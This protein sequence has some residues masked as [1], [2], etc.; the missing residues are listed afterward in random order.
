MEDLT[1]ILEGTRLP[2]LERLGLRD[3][4]RSDD[5]AEMIA[6]AAITQ[7]LRAVDL[8]LGTLGDEGA[9]ALLASPA[10]KRLAELDLHHHYLSDEMMA[11][12]QKLGPRVNLEDQEE[13][14]RDGDEEYRTVAVGE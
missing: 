10:I 4:D 3:S 6:E 13:P 5:V 12:L 9:E 2:R 7:R 8:S 1:P 11:R 14:D